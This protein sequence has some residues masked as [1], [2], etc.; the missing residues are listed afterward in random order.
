MAQQELRSRFNHRPLAW[1]RY[2]ATQVGASSKNRILNAKLFLYETR[3]TV[4]H[5]PGS[6]N[7]D[8]KKE[9]LSR[10]SGRGL[11][12]NNQRNRRELLL[13][14]I[15][16]VAVMSGACAC[17]QGRRHRAGRLSPEDALIAHEHET[18]SLIQ[19]KDLKAFAS[20]LAEEFYDVF[21]DG[22]ERTRSELLEFLSEA[23]LKNYRL[24]DFRVT[25][26]NQDAA[27]V[28]Y[29][30]HARALIQGN[31]IAMKNSVT[32]GW[33]RRGGRWLNVSA[34]ASDSK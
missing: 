27:I 1:C 17:M 31:E 24:A 13:L 3:T 26:L 11:S 25:M 28:T 15:L 18:W 32:A 10:Q 12:M 6:I 5:I 22:E 33:A 9:P 30:V 29:Q 19:R 34:V 23:D 2:S 4:P 16:A 8:M 20:Y 14:G 21:P 7:K